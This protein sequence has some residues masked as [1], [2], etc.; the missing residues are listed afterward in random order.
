MKRTACQ[1]QN[2]VYLHLCIYILFTRVVDINV[3]NQKNI[4][5]PNSL[6]NIK[7]KQTHICTFFETGNIRKA[8]HINIYSIELKQGE[9]TNVG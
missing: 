1:N 6:P 7:G 4:K 2:E 3:K 5:D 9:L 8:K